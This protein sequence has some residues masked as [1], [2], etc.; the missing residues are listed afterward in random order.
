MIAML[1]LGKQHG[2][3]RLREAVESALD[4]GSH[5]V[6]AIR[7]LLTASQERRTELPAIEI[8]LL[9]RYERPLPMMNDYDQLLSAGVAQ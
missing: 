4:A 2:Y 1:A 6:S 5:D 3:D 8:G 9:G 7:Y